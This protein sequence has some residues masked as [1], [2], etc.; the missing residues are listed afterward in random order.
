MVAVAVEVSVE[1]REPVAAVV[2]EAVAVGLQ[3]LNHKIGFQLSPAK[4]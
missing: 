4:R 2:K 3:V 1:R